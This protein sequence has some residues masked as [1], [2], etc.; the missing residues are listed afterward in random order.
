MASVAIWLT[1]QY[2]QMVKTLILNNSYVNKVKISLLHILIII[3]IDIWKFLK[4]EIC[5]PKLFQII[6][7]E[8][9]MFVLY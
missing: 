5:K 2:R 9:S 7:F 3:T 6:N 8:E 4:K 1:V